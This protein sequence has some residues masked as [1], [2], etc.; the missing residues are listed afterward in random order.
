LLVALAGAMGSTAAQPQ[1][2][3]DPTR[4]PVGIFADVPDATAP[5]NQLQSVMISPTRSAAIINGVVVEL[6]AK[7]G[8][9]VLTRVA[10]DEVVLGSG[11]SRQVLK[12]HPGVEKL[13]VARAKPVA[14]AAAKSAPREAKPEAAR[15]AA[16][17]AKT[18]AKDPGAT[19][20]R[21]TGAR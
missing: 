4:P 11:S 8:D 10:E 6:G 5:G 16:P 15:E 3:T 20:D 19:A 17:K 12:L 2:M 21:D 9:A 7:Y 14:P 1:V 18:R 13:D